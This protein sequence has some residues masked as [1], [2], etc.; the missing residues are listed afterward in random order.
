M[1]TATKQ[2][3]H[4]NQKK[5]LR[6]IAGEA[7]AILESATGSGKTL[8]EVEWAK[9]THKPRTIFV[10]PNCNIL[11]DMREV[12]TDIIGEVITDAYTLRN[13]DNTVVNRSVQRCVEWLDN[14]EAG[15]LL[16]THQ[17]FRLALKHYSIAKIRSI[18]SNC[19]VAVDE[20]HHLE[21]QNIIGQILSK[22]LASDADV[23]L[24]TATF[25]RADYARL[26]G[27]KALSKFKT[28]LYHTSEYLADNGMEVDIKFIDAPI[29][30]TAG[31]VEAETKFYGKAVANA[32]K[33][34]LKAGAAHP[35]LVNIGSTGVGMRLNPESYKPLILA[36]DK[37]K[38]SH[39]DAVET[40]DAFHA[41]YR[42]GSIQKMYDVVL[43]NGV[44]AEGTNIPKADTLICTYLSDSPVKLAQLIGRPMRRFKGKDQVKV[45]FVLPVSDETSLAELEDTFTSQLFMRLEFGRLDGY[46]DKAGLPEVD[47][48]DKTPELI[49]EPRE[50]IYVEGKEAITIFSEN[51][52]RKLKRTIASRS[53][54]AQKFYNKAETE[55]ELARML[56]E[57][58]EMN[59]ETRERIIRKWNGDNEDFILQA[60]LWQAEFERE[61]AGGKPMSREM[62]V[63]GRDWRSQYARMPLTRIAVLEAL[64]DWRWTKNI[65]LPYDKARVVIRRAGIKSQ[66]EF[67][68]WKRPSNIPSN[69]QICYRRMGTWVNGYHFFSQNDPRPP[70]PHL[71]RG[72]A[73]KLGRENGGKVPGKTWLRSHGY[74]WLWEDRY[75]SPERYKNLRWEGI[76][77]RNERR[78]QSCLKKALDEYPAIYKKLKARPGSLW[79]QRNKCSNV[80]KYRR[81]HP[82]PFAAIDRKYAK[83]PAGSVRASKIDNLTTARK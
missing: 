30:G 9:S 82:A 43:F 35:I 26:V 69:P 54:E 7:R 15:T 45:R 75:R 1:S 56:E 59:P 51:V 72:I 34:E 60:K 38:L 66:G 42:D 40:R 52:L 27:S 16:V 28:T 4:P 77:E 8:I 10:A 74:G 68:R 83:K 33:A 55:V 71:R 24:A 47:T 50:A 37:A 2:L 70:A 48:E 44:G 32:I 79:L 49:P 29:A 61:A 78:S 57:Q 73:I 36:L 25:Y 41:A 63:K 81:L 17:T 20:C 39:L 76:K 62:R 46:R 58:L 12:V 3:K 13:A 23:L 64:D 19:A 80:Y 22:I 18:F 21:E 67:N 11:G 53:P 65:W 5:A 31:S 6:A 14:H